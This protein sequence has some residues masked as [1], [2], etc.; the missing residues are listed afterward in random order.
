MK[1]FTNINPILMKV[2]ETPNEYAKAIVHRYYYALPN[3]GSHDQ[4]INNCGARYK[5][6]IKCALIEVENIILE[7]EFII[8]R[9]TGTGNELEGY[10]MDKINV[11]D[12]IQSELYKLE[13]E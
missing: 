11:Y 1:R 2:P 6:A 8:A 13:S 3:N 7:L 10:I 5:E 4:G 9:M 12:A